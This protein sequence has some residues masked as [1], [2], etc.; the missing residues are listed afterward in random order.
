[1]TSMNLKLRS[2]EKL[3]INGAVIKCDRRVTVEILNDVSFLLEGHVLQADKA[4][5]FDNRDVCMGL[6]DVQDSIARNRFYDAL[7]QIRNLYEI[8]ESILSRASRLISAA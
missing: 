7:V 6:L 1:M 2:G 4:A 3:Y 8:E 5:S